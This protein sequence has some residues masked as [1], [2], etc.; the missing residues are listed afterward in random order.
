MK[1]D[2]WPP[3]A[4][5][6]KIEP[7]PGSDGGHLYGASTPLPYAAPC[8]HHA[9]SRAAHCPY[10]SSVRIFSRSA[11]PYS[12]SGSTALRYEATSTRLGRSRLASRLDPRVG[13]RESGRVRATELRPRHAPLTSASR[14][15][16]PARR[17]AQHVLP[18]GTV[19]VAVEADALAEIGRVPEPVVR[20]QRGEFVTYGLGEFAAV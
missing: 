6:A 12:L 8:G 13:R 20:G 19:P 4:A 16:R 15:R 14:E 17:T 5:D 9:P 2:P 18:F 11:A 1:H 7:V 3:P 10:C